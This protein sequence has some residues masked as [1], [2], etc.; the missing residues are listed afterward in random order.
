MSLQP[1]DTSPEAPTT[2]PRRWL[3]AA[4][5]A[6]LAMV[7]VG[8]AIGFI[9]F[10]SQLRG[11]EIRPDRNADGIVVLTGGSSRVSDA[12]ELLAGGYG[13]RLLISGVHPTNAASDIS[14][15]LPD[16]SPPDNSLPDN[17]TLLSCCVD[18]DRSAVNTR[19]NAAETRRWA[20]DRGFKSLIVVT[21][22]YHM[23]RAIV[24]LSHAMPDI[25]LIPFAVVG[26][27]WR[28]EP[29]WT[30]GA[31][32]RLLLSE[33]AKYVAAEV[34]VSL[35]E[36]GFELAPEAAEQPTTGSIAPRKPATAAAN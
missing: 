18:L 23:P 15:S 13:K 1:A 7:F 16:N 3:R 32:L 29:W 12:M 34:R 14:R 10:L 5:V 2:A 35:A 19:S 17:Q 21:S 4:V 9:G 30:S 36:A 22:N 6:V 28:D 11:A 25:A 27:T 20:R 24:E 31:T 8:A 33:Y 26:D